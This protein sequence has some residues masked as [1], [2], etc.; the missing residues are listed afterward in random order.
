MRDRSFESRE[1]RT[2]K[3]MHMNDI[4]DVIVIEDDDFDD[5]ED[6]RNQARDHRTQAGRSRSR[7]RG[8]PTAIVRGRGRPSSSG[9]IVGRPSNAGPVVRHDT[10]GLSYG[11]LIDVGAQLLAAIQPLPAAPAS[12]GETNTDVANLMLYQRALAEHAKRDE[13]LRTLGS[14]ASKFLA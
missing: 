1:L 14:L 8:R 7:V 11:I 9:R 10:G 13:Q 5:F 12:S 4:A 6:Y 3:E 2:I